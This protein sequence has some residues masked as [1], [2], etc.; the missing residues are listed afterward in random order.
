MELHECHQLMIQEKAEESLKVGAII[1][2][3]VMVSLN[4]L[5]PFKELLLAHMAEY[6]QNMRDGLAN[7]IYAQGKRRYE[8]A[9]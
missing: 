2:E 5:Y 6:K 9:V 8:R 4:T 7:H 3:D 1:D